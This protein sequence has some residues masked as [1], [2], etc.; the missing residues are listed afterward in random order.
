M[1]EK[2]LKSQEKE[3]QRDIEV[4]HRE[5]RL[6]PFDEMERW[7]DEAFNRRFFGHPGIFRFPEIR[8][9]WS[10][11]ELSPHIDIYEEEREVVVKAELP[12][13]KKADLDINISDDIITIAGEKKAEEKVEKKN[14]FRLERS[15]GS[16]TRRLRLPAATVGEKAKATFKDGILEI[17]IPKTEEAQAKVKKIHVE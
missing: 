4:S 11:E 12:G 13:V 2:S 6:T 7:M 10:A 5:R 1:S 3:E 15:Y 9:P 17:R 16:I 14:Y 8:M